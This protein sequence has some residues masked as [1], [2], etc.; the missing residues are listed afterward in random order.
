MSS[1]NVFDYFCSIFIIILGL[2]IKAIEYGYITV[3]YWK[4]SIC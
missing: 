1:C 3:E 4:K 2:N